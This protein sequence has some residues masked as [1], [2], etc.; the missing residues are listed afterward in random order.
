MQGRLFVLLAGFLAHCLWAIIIV[1][2]P[3]GASRQ[4]A[5]L[6]PYDYEEFLQKLHLPANFDI[7][8]IDFGS[9]TANE[10][11]FVPE[12]ILK[13]ITVTQFQSIV[14]MD[15]VEKL[16]KLGKRQLA[17]LESFTMALRPTAEQIQQLKPEVFAFL[18][19]WYTLSTCHLTARQFNFLLHYKP[20]PAWANE[21]SWHLMI[22]M[23]HDL[24]PV[25]IAETV[26]LNWLA[27][28]ETSS[29]SNLPE[30]CQKRLAMLK[31]GAPRTL[32]L[33]QSTDELSEPSQPEEP[34]AE[35]N[36]AERTGKE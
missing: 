31:D 2:Y 16:N 18:D 17:A 28:T 34:S 4:F 10:L 11:S 36:S 32:I 9:A 19:P 27:A 7:K 14:N 25:R 29:S 35:V 21:F 30:D 15:A 33:A 26:A 24:N 20:N 6:R 1:N 8:W 12:G 23:R 5:I 3:D 22:S 13:L